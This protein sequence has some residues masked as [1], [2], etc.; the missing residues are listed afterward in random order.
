MIFPFRFNF[1][2]NEFHTIK[3]PVVTFK[4]Q[5]FKSEFK[6]KKIKSELRRI[7]IKYIYF[8]ENMYLFSIRVR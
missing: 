7:I 4:R 1:N 6:L 8:S 2:K 5:F 3:Y